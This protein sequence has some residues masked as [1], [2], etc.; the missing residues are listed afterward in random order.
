MFLGQFSDNTGLFSVMYG[1]LTWPACCEN[2]LCRAQTFRQGGAARRGHSGPQAGGALPEH[3]PLQARRA[4]RWHLKLHGWTDVTPTHTPFTQSS[5]MTVP[6]FKGDRTYKLAMAQTRGRSVFVGGFVF[7]KA[8][9]SWKHLSFAPNKYE[10][11]HFSTSCVCVTA[12]V[13]DARPWGASI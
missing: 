8:L 11:F 7:G 13:P 4:T 12:N 9:Y 10:R 1:F 6:T 5:H 2:V 3:V